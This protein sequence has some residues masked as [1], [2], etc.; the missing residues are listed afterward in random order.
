M[1]WLLW[2]VHKSVYSFQPSKFHSN[3]NDCL[4][5]D[6]TVLNQSVF[7]LVFG[8]EENNL[9]PTKVLDRTFNTKQCLSLCLFFQAHFLDPHDLCSRYCDLQPAYVC[10]RGASQT[11]TENAGNRVQKSQTTSLSFSWLQ[12][13]NEV[14]D[15]SITLIVFCIILNIMSSRHT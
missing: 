8:A 4:H 1:R 9:Q 12:E 10:L 14:E 3:L 7:Q 15:N 13:V 6:Q 5:H 2:A 11:N